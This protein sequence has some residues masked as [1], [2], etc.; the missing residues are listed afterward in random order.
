MGE[1]GETVNCLTCKTGKRWWRQQFDGKYKCSVCEG[2]PLIEG[3]GRPDW[4]DWMGARMTQMHGPRAPGDAEL[5]QTYRD[6][7]E[8]AGW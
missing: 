7:L 8:R 2:D 4:Y 3:N 6:E 5:L 1:A